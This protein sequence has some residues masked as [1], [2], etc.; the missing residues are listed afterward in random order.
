M[1]HTGFDAPLGSLELHCIQQCQLH[2]FD[3]LNKLDLPYNRIGA[4]MVAWDSAQVTQ[5]FHYFQFII[6]NQ[7]I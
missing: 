2:I 7:D 1:L 6:G 3:I 4:T 5:H